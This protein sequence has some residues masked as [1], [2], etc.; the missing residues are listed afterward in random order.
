MAL[1]ADDAQQLL[2]AGHG[3]DA[4]S[5][6]T[7]ASHPMATGMGSRTGN[8]WPGTNPNPADGPAAAPD[9]RCCSRVRCADGTHELLN[10]RL[11]D[12]PAADRGARTP[13]P[14][15]RSV[16][17]SPA[18]TASTRRTARSSIRSSRPR[19]PTGPAPGRRAGNFIPGT[20]NDFGGSSTTRVRGA[21]ARRV[22]PAAGFT[23]VLRYQQLQQRRHSEP[24][25]GAGAVTDRIRIT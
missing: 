9:A 10:D 14:T 21:A 18:R 7:G 15:R 25:S 12:R 6:S 5:T 8:D 24:L 22:Y 17:R 19:T 13:R 20:T 4:W 3:L 2:C 11:R 1:D 23:T 16:T